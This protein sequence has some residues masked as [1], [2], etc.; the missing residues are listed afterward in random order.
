MNKYQPYLLPVSIL[1]LAITQIPGMVES[2]RFNKCYTEARKEIRKNLDSSY[3]PVNYC[4]GGK[5]YR[6]GF[7]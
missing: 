7:L 3:Y 1:I 5:G 6:P 4:S 2:T